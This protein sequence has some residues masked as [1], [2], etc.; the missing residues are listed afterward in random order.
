MII[1][2]NLN[3]IKHFLL[4]KIYIKQKLKNIVLNKNL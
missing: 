4:I 1:N 3:N 2:L